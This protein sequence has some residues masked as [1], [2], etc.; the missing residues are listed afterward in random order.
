MDRTTRTLILGIGNVLW[1]DEGFGV[2]AADYLYRHYKTPPGVTVMDGGT[3]GI[4]LLQHVEKADLLVIFDAID[5]GLPPASMKLIEGDD[6]PNYMG[7]KKVSLHQT[8][9][10]EVLAMAEML[11]RSPREQLLVGVQPCLI[12]DFGGSLHEKTRS[13]IEPAVAAAVEWLAARDVSLEK[14][15]EPRP[16]TDSIAGYE[17][18]MQR[19]ETERPSEADA[20]RTGDDRVLSSPH[21][22]VAPRPR[23]VGDSP[24]QVDVDHRGKY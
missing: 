8:G 10:Q 20:C 2:R 9:F 6:V 5:Y 11:G 22:R 16:D 1:A 12:E 18:D 23:P 3:Q 13:R 21:Y 19:Y 4:Y 14:L 15:N 24:M 7:A 17:I